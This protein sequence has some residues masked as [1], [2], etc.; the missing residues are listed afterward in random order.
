MR[1]KKLMQTHKRNH[2]E[3][4]NLDILIYIKEIIIIIIFY[5]KICIILFT[6]LCFSYI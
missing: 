3:E 4:V 5:F 6:T 2:D 1:Q